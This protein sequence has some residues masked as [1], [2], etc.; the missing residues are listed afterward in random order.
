MINL[1]GNDTCAVLEQ[2]PGQRTLSRSNLQ[3]R[4]TLAQIER[5]NDFLG[6]A[7]VDE[8][9]LTQRFLRCY[10]HYPGR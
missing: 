10:S 7:P 9:I 4:L 6:L 8:K 5:R 2:Q 1:H 3:N